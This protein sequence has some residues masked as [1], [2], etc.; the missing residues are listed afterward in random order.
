MGRP[1]EQRRSAKRQ[2]RRERA[3]VKKPSR[4]QRWT[5]MGG[6]GTVH[7]KAGRKKFE[8]VY[9]YATGLLEAHQRGDS[10]TEKSVNEIRRPLYTIK[11]FPRPESNFKEPWRPTGEHPTR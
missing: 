7:V 6:A 8:K 3:R 11:F 1:S 9:R 10:L 5:M 4:W 2:G